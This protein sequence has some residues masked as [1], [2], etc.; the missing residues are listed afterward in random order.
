M[1]QALNLN[2]LMTFVVD[3]S[4]NIPVSIYH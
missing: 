3:V 4:H 1:Q 2:G